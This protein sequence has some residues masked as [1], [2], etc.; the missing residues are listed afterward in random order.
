MITAKEVLVLVLALIILVFSNSFKNILEKDTSFTI[1]SL[2][3]FAIILII[4]VAAKKLTAY[5]Y[6]AEEETKIWNFQRYGLYERSYFK[7]PIPIGIILPFLLSIITFGSIPWFAVTESDVK[8]TEAR[9]AKRHQIYSFA[10]MT[11][12]HLALISAS[13]ILASLIIAPIAYILNLQ[14]LAK[15][16]IYFA[17]FN[18][19]PL[20]KLDGSRVFFGSLI[21]WVF[22]AAISLIALSYA[23]LLV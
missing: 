23:L 10:E 4:Y 2:F 17:C 14:E 9:A 5:Y 12:W 3:I 13:G 8:P 7:Y 6:E 16:S 19:L 1:N 15:A 20:G 21:L 22:L 11:E 18:L